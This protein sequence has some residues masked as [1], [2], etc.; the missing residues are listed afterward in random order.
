MSDRGT[1]WGHN[2]STGGRG[3]VAAAVSTLRGMEVMLLELLWRVLRGMGT[4]NAGMC[5]LWVVLE[6]RRVMTNRGKEQ[7]SLDCLG[8]VGHAS[9]GLPPCT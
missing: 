8:S 3:H 1:H 5:V 4:L 7:A 2:T 6:G 9:T